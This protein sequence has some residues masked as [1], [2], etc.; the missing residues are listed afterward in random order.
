MFT[1]GSNDDDSVKFGVWIAHTHGK[2]DEFERNHGT[3]ETEEKSA[4][5]GVNLHKGRTERGGWISV[6][7]ESF[8]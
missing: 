8:F 7:G 4:G 2:E 6:W 5:R 3:M 1:A